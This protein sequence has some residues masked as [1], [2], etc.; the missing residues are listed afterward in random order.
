MSQQQPPPRVS[1]VIPTYN[2]ARYIGT[3][4]DSILGQSMSDLEV[5]VY[6]DGSS[7]DTLRVVDEYARRDARLKVVR[8]TNGG[9]ANARNRGFAATHPLSEF[10]TFFDHDD[11]WEP[12]AL[13]SLVA[14][15]E[16]HPECPA[17][18]GVA[19]CIDSDGAFFPG[20]DHADNMRRRS[21]VLNGRVVPIPRKAPTGFGAILIQ[22]YITTPG[23]SLV[24]RWAFEAVG[25]FE[26]SAVPCDDWDMNLRLSRLGDF[27]FVDEI[28][29]NWRRHPQATSNLTSRWRTAYMIT[30]HR[31]LHSPNNSP[32][33][34]DAARLAIRHEA[35]RLLGEAL[36]EARRGAAQS[37]AKKVARTA[38][39]GSVYFDVGYP[40]RG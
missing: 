23:T 3:T 33:Q 25:G 20:D 27:A 7:D 4:L 34:R 39:L 1:V 12:D 14:A 15:L 21:A 11:V 8:A 5:V 2:S 9:I 16:A 31:S 30:R 40:I 36:T 18:H 35:G 24:R 17:A 22:N 32:Q 37:V 38:L 13:K 10:V 26:P 19:R 28:V 29:L 6:D